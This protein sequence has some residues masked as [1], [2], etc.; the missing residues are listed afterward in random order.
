MIKKIYP[1][2][3]RGNLEKQRAIRPCADLAK[4]ITDKSKESFVLAGLLVVTDKVIDK[5]TQKEL[6]EVLEMTQVGK[7]PL[8]A[9]RQTGRKAGYFG[10]NALGGRAG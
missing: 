8:D 10:G 2:T 6:K 1:L 3:L 9:G 4:R 7:M 5:D